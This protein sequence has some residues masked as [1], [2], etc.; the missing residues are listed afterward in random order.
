MRKECYNNIM[1]RDYKDGFFGDNEVKVF[2]GPEVE[3]TLA[4]GKTT[5]FLATNSLTTDQILELC[6]MNNCEAIYYGA[7]RCYQH[8]IATQVFQM[9]KFLADGYYIT[10]D[11]PYSMHDQVKKRFSHFWTHKKFIP[12]CS[13]IFPHTDEDKQLCFKIDDED[14][15]ATNKGVW[16]QSMADF[17]KQAGY[18]DWAQYKQDKILDVGD[19]IPANKETSNA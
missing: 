13:I 5:L 12:F 2:V 7:N 1:N 10:V 16:T 3:H 18:T 19:W 6:V 9:S 15:N 14:F 4:Y 11:Y 17:K 8:N